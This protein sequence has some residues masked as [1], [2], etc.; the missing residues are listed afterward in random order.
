MPISFG[1]PERSRSSTAVYSSE[2][3]QG[4]YRKSKPTFR[5][6][7]P[8]AADMQQGL[9]AAKIFFEQIEKWGIRSNYFPEFQNYFILYFKKYASWNFAE[10]NHVLNVY[11]D[12]WKS[13]VHETA[14]FFKTIP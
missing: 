3:I 11:P 5:P 12:T 1:G 10:E 6:L 14:L 9:S 8:T 7:S 13:V 2:K 4:I